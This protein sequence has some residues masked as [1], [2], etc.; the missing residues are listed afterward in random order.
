MVKLL[1]RR[2]SPSHTER[3]DGLPPDVGAAKDR[4]VK[5]GDWKL[6][7]G[8]SAEVEQATRDDLMDSLGG[9]AIFA[10]S[11]ERLA[12]LDNNAN[13]S[14][15]PWVR[16]RALKKLEAAHDDHAALRS[17]QVEH[18]S[19]HRFPGEDMETARRRAGLLRAVEDIKRQTK[20]V[21]DRMFP[22]ELK[23]GWLGRLSSEAGSIDYTIGPHGKVPGDKI[24]S[25]VQVTPDVLYDR[26]KEARR[27]DIS[28][29]E[30]PDQ[31]PHPSVVAWNEV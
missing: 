14:L 3:S 28:G 1:P 11:H 13:R 7:N 29:V 31:Y 26:L 23:P 19:V 30:M 5:F 4:I 25:V 12:H 2:A 27:N 21:H 9:A 22:D 8:R 6:P 15:I 17:H 10:V 16:N 24:E 20:E 18:G